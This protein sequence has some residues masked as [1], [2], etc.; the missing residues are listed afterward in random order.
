VRC[1]KRSINAGE[2]SN[3]LFDILFVKKQRFGINKIRDLEETFMRD[4]G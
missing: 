4:R 2:I 1:G 3:L